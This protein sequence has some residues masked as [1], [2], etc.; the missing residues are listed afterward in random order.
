MVYIHAFFIFSKNKKSHYKH[1]EIDFKKLEAS[2]LYA[3]SNR[4]DFFKEKI[5][6]RAIRIDKNASE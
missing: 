2:P 3:S 5:D 1:L 6:F 4:Y